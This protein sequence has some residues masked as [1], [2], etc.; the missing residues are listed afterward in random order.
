MLLFQYFFLYKR[1]IHFRIKG[2]RLRDSDAYASAY[3][4]GRSL[5]KCICTRNKLIEMSQV[6][7]TNRKFQLK[8]TMNAMESKDFLR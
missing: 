1:G 2:K 4:I 5:C 8:Y 7:R 6:R 3:A